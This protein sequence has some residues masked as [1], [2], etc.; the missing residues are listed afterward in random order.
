MD[1][2]MI[3]LREDDRVGCVL[4]FSCEKTKIATSC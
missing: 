3:I 1:L 2:E 4:I